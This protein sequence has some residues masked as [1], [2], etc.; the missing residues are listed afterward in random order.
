MRVCYPKLPFPPCTSLCGNRTRQNAFVRRLHAAAHECMAALLLLQPGPYVTPLTSVLIVDDE[1]SIRALL[2]RWVEMLGL[3]VRTASNADEAVTTLD[4]RPCDLAI[5]DVMMPGRNGLWLAAELLR[6]YPDMAVVLATG[7]VASI[8]NDSPAVADLLIKP[9]PRERFVLALDRGRQWRRQAVEEREWQEHL[10]Q[11]LRQGVIDVQRVLES[12]RALGRDEA[13]I[14][15]RL[16]HSRMPEVMAHGER[17]ARFALSIMRALEIDFAHT[18]L[19][20]Q[21]ARFHDVGKLAMPEAVL[22]KPSPLT[23]GEAAIMRGHVE[24]GADILRATHSL[25]GA[26][27]AV[28]A[29]H[30]WY[31]GAGYPSRLAGKSIPLQS[32]IIAV[33][34]AY[35]AMTQDRRYRTR[36]TSTEAISE[37][38]RGTPSQFDPD[39][40]SAFLNIL[41]RH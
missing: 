31:G 28:L 6:S 39:V 23:R 3:E 5:I 26:A 30:E 17:V 16:G 2:A 20:V 22:T 9:F 10:A 21:A 7:N 34:D 14:L 33:A 29:S 35:D 32:R 36:L 11:A 15:A 27:P 8:G 41:G 4:A 19:F 25:K 38:L 18:Q 24:A 1:P 40:V 13:E 37:L 12:G